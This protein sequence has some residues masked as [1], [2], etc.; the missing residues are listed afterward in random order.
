MEYNYGLHVPAALTS[1][2]EHPVTLDTRLGGHPEPVSYF[3]HTGEETE[4]GAL[5]RVSWA[6]KGADRHAEKRV[7]R[8]ARI[9]WSMLQKLESD[10]RLFVRSRLSCL[11]F[12]Y[13]PLLGRT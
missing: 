12:V 9:I 11:R 10:S 4:K 5:G 7:T 2:K 1:G 3:V 8:G 6:P 13:L